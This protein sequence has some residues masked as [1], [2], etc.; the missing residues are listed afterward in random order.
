MILRNTNTEDSNC[1]YFDKYFSHLWTLSQ[2]DKCGYGY[3]RDWNFCTNWKLS[4]CWSL[5]WRN[6]W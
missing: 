4:F 5:M 6:Y 3:S 2:F 1:F